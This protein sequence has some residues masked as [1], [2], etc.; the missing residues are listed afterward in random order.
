LTRPS[1]LS[2]IAHGGAVA[3]EAV[4]IAQRALAALAK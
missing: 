4:D 1:C 3:R 2:A